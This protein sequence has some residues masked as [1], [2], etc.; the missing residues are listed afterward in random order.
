M[1]MN[2]FMCNFI[3]LHPYPFIHFLFLMR[4]WVT[5]QQFKQISPDLP[6]LDDLLHLIQRTPKCSKA[7]RES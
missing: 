6:F 3:P 1:Q 2:T 4:V 5:E 7:S